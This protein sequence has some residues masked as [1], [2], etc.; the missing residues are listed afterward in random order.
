MRN[1]I[2]DIERLID[3]ESSRDVWVVYK[4][5]DGL[6]KYYSLSNLLFEIAFN[7]N[8][9]AKTYELKHSTFY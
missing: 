7:P 4:Y 2:L 3:E 9:V 6:D 1:L 8:K 5:E